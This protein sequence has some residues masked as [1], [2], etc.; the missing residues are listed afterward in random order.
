[1]PRQRRPKVR[2]RI[3]NPGQPG[4]AGTASQD[5]RGR[6]HGDGTM[7]PARGEAVMRRHKWAVLALVAVGTFM[8]ALDASIVNI[9]LPSIAR[10]FRAPVGG[11]VEW[12]I[13][14]YLVVIAGTLLTFGRLSDLVGRK[15]VWMTGLA[16]FVLGSALCGAATSLPMLIVAR[17]MQGLGGALIFAPGLAIIADAFPPAERGRALGVNAVVF[18]IGTSFGPTLGGLITEH[19]T[20]RW[21]FYINLPLGAAGF[22]ASSR[23]LARSE[24]RTREPLDLLG[25]VLIAVGFSLLTVTLSFGQEWGWASAHLLT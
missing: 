10:T 16:L 1:A 23:L 7:E 14:V 17:A 12:V 24:A 13:I 5:G 25:A 11:A 6:A 19:L 22:I 20:W 15:P 18:A 9:G 2:A 4:R 3:G 21:I 8:T